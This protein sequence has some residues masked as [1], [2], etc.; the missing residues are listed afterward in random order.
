MNLLLRTL[1]Q[2]WI[3]LLWLVWLLY[4][5]LGARHLKAVARRESRLQRASHI[6]PLVLAAL[7]FLLPGRVCGVLSTVFIARSWASYDIGVTLVT[8]GL[9]YTVQARRHLGA[10][11]SGT[12][13][14]KQEHSLVRSGPYRRV[15]HPIYTGLLLAIAGSALA[16]AEWRGVLAVLLAAVAL[17]IKL[18]REER[19]MLERFGNDYAEYRKASWA[20]LPGVY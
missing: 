14:L 20:L 6:I 18:R 11:W 16:L 5:R 13:T 8:L 4:W 19:W 12:I 1:L 15:R 10:N 17:I 9:G 7:L 3:P 2:E